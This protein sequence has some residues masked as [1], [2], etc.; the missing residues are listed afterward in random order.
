MKQSRRMRRRVTAGLCVA[1]ACALVTACSSSSKPSASASSSTSTSASA[2]PSAV[3]SAAASSSAPTAALSSTPA[4][5]A[6]S[7][8]TVASALPSVAQSL[9]QIVNGKKVLLDPYWLDDF[10]TAFTNWMQRDLAALGVQ[11]T[12]FNANA[13]ASAS[14]N[15]IDTA[16][17]SGQYAGIIW[18]P[19]DETAAVSTVKRIEAAKIPQVVFGNIPEL[20]GYPV[21]QLQTASSIA[22]YAPGVIAAEYI[23]AHPA[24]GPHPLLAFTASSPPNTNCTDRLQGLLAGLKSVDPQSKVVFQLGA[25]SI[26]QADSQM[27]DFIQRGIKFNVYDGCGSS[28]SEG[29]YA[30]IKAAGLAGATNKVPQHVF[31]MTDDGDPTQV[32]AVW[33]P[34]SA[35]MLTTLLAPKVAAQNGVNLLAQVLEGQIPRTSTKTAAA[36]WTPILPDCSYHGI[37]TS[38]YQGVP[39]FKVPACQIAGTASQYL[40]TAAQYVSATPSPSS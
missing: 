17:S 39:G 32:S 29:G 11:S 25:A 18:A 26:S 13:S 9:K 40:G 23:K 1:T 19:I 31:I 24:L 14:I 12:I 4:S 37:I 2:P 8:S 5:A 16:I 33:D 10:G 6:A 34:T 21:P 3:Q 22:L 7:S 38:N 36:T 15:E 28:P 20:T 35:A 30:G 27:T